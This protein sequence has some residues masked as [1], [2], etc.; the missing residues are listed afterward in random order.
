MTKRQL[1]DQIV[2][3]NQT[4]EPGF[5]ADFK[6]EDLQEYLDHLRVV[7]QPRLT[8][9][10]YRYEKYFL[11]QKTMQKAVQTVPAM[12]TMAAESAGATA[13][14]LADP[15][16]DARA[17]ADDGGLWS[18]S[19]ADVEPADESPE[20]P[21]YES[22]RARVS[23]GGFVYETP[24]MPPSV[25]QAPDGFDDEAPSFDEEPVA[26]GQYADSSATESDEDME[27]WLF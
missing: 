14:A 20:V 13:T 23:D 27:S 7:D 9:E 11:M 8:G 10:T 15:P 3:V 1:I 18:S 17:S 5:L 16:A 4:A 21:A 22:P 26:V 6:D 2:T 24:Y 19:E 12:Q 25:S